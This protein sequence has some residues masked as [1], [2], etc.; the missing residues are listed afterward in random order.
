MMTASMGGT[1]SAFGSLSSIRL[2]LRTYPAYSNLLLDCLFIF[3]ELP[4]I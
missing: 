4:K 1:S 2:A 3:L